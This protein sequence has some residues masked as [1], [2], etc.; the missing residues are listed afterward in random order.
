MSSE[1]RRM[2]SGAASSGLRPGEAGPFGNVV[3]YQN[4]LVYRNRQFRFQTKW[5][6]VNSYKSSYGKTDGSTYFDDDD[7]KD[8][9]VGGYRLPTKE[10]CD[11]LI[12]AS[13]TGSEYNGV[14]GARYACVT[15]NVTYATSSNIKGFIFFPDD[16]IISG[17]ALSV[18]SSTFTWITS[19]ELDDLLEQGVLFFPLAGYYRYGWSNTNKSGYNWTSTKHSGGTYQYHLYLRQ[20][21]SMEVAYNFGLYYITN[22][23]RNI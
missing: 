9:S 10:E 3:F 20:D 23:V 11:Y 7:L 19:A 15:T 18:N 6:E 14:S 5:N 12:S 8:V 1:R 13:R 4:P 2:L 16:A 22:L 17:K 21:G